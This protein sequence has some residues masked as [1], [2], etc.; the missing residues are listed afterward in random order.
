[1]TERVTHNSQ[2]LAIYA[3]VST[4]RQEEEETI[5]TQLSAVREF[6]KQRGYT[7]VQE[8]MDDGW[9]GDILAR[10]QLDK[11]R[12]DVSKK[13]WQAVLVYDP[14]RLARRYSYQELIMDEL[15]EKGVDVLFVTTPSPTTGEEKI[16]HGVKGLFAEYERV[17]ITERFRLGKMRKAKEGHVLASEAPYG[18]VFKPKSETDGRNGRYEINEPEAKVVRMI[19]SWIA[20]ERLTIRQVIKRLHEFRILPRWSKRGVWS[21]STLGHLLRNKTYIG[22]AHYGSSYSVVPENPINKGKYRKIRKTSSRMKPEDEWIKIPAP[23]IL[24]T[25]LFERV[26]R[27]LRR[28]FE[29]SRRNRKNEYLLSRLIRHSCGATMAGEGPHT[30]RNLYYR[31]TDRVRSFPLPPKCNERGLDARAADRLVWGKISELMSSPELLKRQV[32]RWVER[33]RNKSDERSIRLEPI[34]AEIAK[35]KREED[36]YARAYGAGAIGLSQLSEFTSEIRNRVSSLEQNLVAEGSKRSKDITL[37]GTEEEIEALASGAR[38]ALGDLNFQ[39]KRLIVMNIIDRIVASRNELKISGSIPV[40]ST[41]DVTLCSIHRHDA[42]TN[43]L[44]HVKIRP[45]HRDRADTNRHANCEPK[46]RPIV[47]FTDAASIPFEITIGLPD[48]WYDRVITD[49]DRRGRITH[50]IAPPS[51]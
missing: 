26:Q 45:I 18:Y 4:A 20:D 41:N 16:L 14:D 1:M 6:A 19:F 9:S 5:K 44:K 51:G 38:A 12:Q 22:E 42:D 47:G 29:M 17:K 21:T 50:S 27:Q 2:L 15:R 24:D 36:R 49:R 13:I 48:P 8:Y 11:L 33:Q 30:G 39:A 43:Q 25:G 40:Q 10:P 23:A 35:L 37:P 34:K 32:K 46:S 3:R 7:I 28:N 31:C